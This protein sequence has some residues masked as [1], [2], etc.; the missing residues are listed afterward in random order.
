LQ[1]SFLALSYFVHLIATVVW[2]GGLFS[3]TLLIWPET[4]RILAENPALHQFLNRLRKRFAPLTN[5]SLAVLWLS[6]LIQL[7]GDPNYQGTLIFDNEWSRV[8]LLKHIAVLGM[9][10]CG[11]I[12][13]FVVAPA[14]E[15]A[16]MLKE[17]GKDDAGEW[18]RQRQREI[19]LT[20][21]NL[22]LGVAVLGFTAWATA[23]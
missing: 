19:R 20:W 16:S 5:F 3:L 2:I 6:G 22:L 4:Q 8:M 10:L 18:Q 7:S 15:R 9:M 13:Q 12:L 1:P 23:L 14:L 11:L 17:R 21:V